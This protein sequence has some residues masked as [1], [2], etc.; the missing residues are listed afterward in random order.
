[1]YKET[2][3]LYWP[4]THLRTTSASYRWRCQVVLL[5]VSLHPPPWPA[6]FI[7][8]LGLDDLEKAGTPINKEQRARLFTP[9]GLD[10]GAETAEEIALSILG[11]I[12][13]VLTRRTGGKL[14]DHGGPIHD[15]PA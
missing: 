5:F 4:S 13:A 9:I 12:Q 14:R 7:A 3:A 2:G 6:W 11:E 10:I 1:M 15:R 8:E